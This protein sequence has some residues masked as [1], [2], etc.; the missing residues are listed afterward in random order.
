MRSFEPT[1][2][3]Q[4]DIFLYQLL[5]AARKGE[6]VDVS[7]ILMRLAADVICHLGF[8]YPLSTPAEETNRP[9]LEA[10]NLVSGCVALYMNWPATAKVFDPLID[11]LGKKAAEDFRIAI[12]VMVEARMALPED[13]KHDLYKMALSD[14]KGEETLLESELWAEAVFFITAGMEAPSNPLRAFLVLIPWK[15]G[16][17]MSA[18][19]S[20]VLFY[21]SRNPEIY[22]KLT[23][24][25]RTT[26]SSGHDIKSGPQLTSCKYLRAVINETLRM[27]PSSIGTLWRQQDLALPSNVGKPFIVDGCVVPPGTMVGLSPYSLLHNKKY[28]PEPFVFRPERH[29]EAGQQGKAADTTRAFAPFGIGSRSCGGRAVA[30]LEASLT[31]A[32]TLWYFDVE[33]AP[34]KLGEVGEGGPG[35]GKGREQRGAYQVW[36]VITAEHHGPNLIFTPRE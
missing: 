17:T 24:E 8:G 14:K 12:Q 7:P 26:F 16:A 32:K 3:S 25:I 19:M 5:P 36:D 27:S 13:A 22:R 4:V 28:F 34:G 30:Y 9:L 10:F 29:L 23:E 33:K 35:M 31:I 11:W 20:G 15:G 2:N 21:I 1:M 18:L 6:A